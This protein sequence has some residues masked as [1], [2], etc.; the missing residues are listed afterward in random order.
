MPNFTLPAKLYMPRKS[1]EFGTEALLSPR[2]EELTN[3]LLSQINLEQRTESV[4]ALEKFWARE[5]ACYLELCKGKGK[6]YSEYLPG[7]EYTYRLLTDL[8]IRLT[9]SSTILALEAGCGSGLTCSLLAT[10]GATTIG[11]DIAFSALRYAQTISLD[12]GASIKIAAADWMNMP[13]AENTFDVAFSLGALEHHPPRIQ[14]RFFSELARVSRRIIVLVP[15]TESPIYMT[16]EEKEFAT[17]PVELVYP[18][19]H[20]LYPVDLLRLCRSSELSVIENAALHIAPPKHIPR[21]YLTL[22]SYEFFS[23]ISSRALC[24]WE[25]SAMRT[26]LLI[27]NQ[28][29]Y[30]QRA[31]FGWFSYVVG[32][33]R[34]RAL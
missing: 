15:N 30:E 25:G 13:F 3:Y 14:Q 5:H 8:I 4:I 11:I 12:Y 26:W 27:E 10:S 33:K 23:D 20:Q 9:G 28:C 18:E 7:R 17:M 24:N 1:F 22:E 21:K 31:K 32:E 19:E 29:S 2:I 34:S 16:M 6:R